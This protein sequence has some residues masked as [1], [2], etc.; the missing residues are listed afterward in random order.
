MPACP[1][2]LCVD[3]KVGDAPCSIC[4]V[5]ECGSLDI[6]VPIELGGPLCAACDAPEVRASN[7]R[8]MAR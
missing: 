3:G 8:L 4:R 7:L 6:A 2:R 5:C 1:F